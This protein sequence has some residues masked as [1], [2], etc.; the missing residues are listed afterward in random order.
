MWSDEDIYEQTFEP[1]EIDNEKVDTNNFTIIIS[2]TYFYTS[3][4]SKDMN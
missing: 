3:T 2:P 4:D 1:E